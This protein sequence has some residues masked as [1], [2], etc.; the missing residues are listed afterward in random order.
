[1]LVCVGYL[2]PQGALMFA[3][4]TLLT[5]LRARSVSDD[6]QVTQGGQRQCDSRGDVSGCGYS[7]V[8]RDVSRKSV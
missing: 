5:T 7:G 2:L 4:V 8:G 3:Y 6:I 1:V